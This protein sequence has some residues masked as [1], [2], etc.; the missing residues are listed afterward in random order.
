MFQ[1]R[2]FAALLVTLLLAA[3][4]HGADQPL[5]E[6]IITASLRATP[7]RELPQSVTVLDGATLHAAG[8][9]HFEDVLGLVPA[10]SWA[11]GSSRPRY[12]QLRGI[13]EVEQYQ[14][15]PNPSVGLL[16][17]DIDFSG[18]GM[19]ATLF[20]LDRIE[21]L[22]GPSST[23]YGANAL[24]GLISMHSRDPGTA[25]DLRTEATAGD[26]GTTALGLAVGDGRTDGT[27]GW[28][29]AAQRYRSDGF[30]RNVYLGRNDTNGYDETTLRGKAV[31]E[32]FPQ[33]HAALTL[34][35]A[36]LDNGYDAWSVD[37]SRITRSN[38][39][40]RDAQRSSGA[41]LRLAFWTGVGQLLSVSSAAVSHSNYS[42][43]GDWGNDG[44]WGVNAPYD[45]FEQHRRARRTLAQDL[46][47]IGDDAHLLF[48]RLRPVLGAYLLR[49][50]E[51]DAQLDVW[52]D[53]YYGNGQSLLN[54]DY[55][56][57]NAAVYG[58]FE[59]RVARRGTLSLG[60]RAEQRTAHYADS[61]DAV[62]PGARDH[63]FGGNLSWAWRTD[64][65][66]EYY[67]TL[68]RG[69]KAGGFNIGAAIDP[70]Q[71][72][73]RAETLWNLEA[74]VRTRIPGPDLDLQTAI[75]AMRRSDMQVYSSRQLLPDNPLTYVFFTGNAAHGDNVGL[76]SEL[77]WR[78]ARRWAYSATAALLN[79]RYLGYRSDGLDLRGRAQAFA[80]AW[81]FSFGASYE[82]PAGWFA[83]ADLQAQDGFYFSA[84][85]N[86]RAQQRELVN[87]RV[88]WRHDGWTASLW[89]RN[90][91]DAHYAVQGFY[92][93]DEPPDFPVKLYLQ[94]GNPRQLGITVTWDG[95]KPVN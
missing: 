73:F 16:I 5:E 69:Y 52:S 39:P 80:P 41:A 84:S 6:I 46:R 22:R 81:Q 87:L 49:L 45:Y 94:N 31:L 60:V 85:H 37:N 9:Q 11:S 36:D 61:S 24:A 62:F 43:D 95:V 88:G 56:A 28:R 75:Y 1:I 89:A 78:P 92:F 33:L 70:A 23:V 77:R 7:L 58:S 19:P 30:R 4:A 86:Q 18:V 64:G 72:Q 15:A 35:Y 76:E 21:V 50:R 47:F 68:A 12:F 59:L 71:R 10:L 74:G 26:Y 38:Q 90:L 8:V 44:F 34:L 48:G 82:H 17:D 51:N 54:S 2:P 66:R 29:V 13:G 57:T 67:A 53:Q 27:A 25:F 55:A 63:L 79:S 91:F 3:A 32:P 65:A 83:R 40:G 93:G 20:D 14:G 42:F